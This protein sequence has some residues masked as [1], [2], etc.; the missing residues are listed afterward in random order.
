MLK[1]GNN[2]IRVLYVVENRSFGGGERGFGQ[3]STNLKKNRFQPFLAAHP[4]GQ[5]EE[6][7]QRAG[8]TFFP[9]DMS[10]KVN[11][12]TTGYLSRLISDHQIHIVHS[13]GA[14]ANFFARMACSRHSSTAVV[15]TVAMLVEGFDVSFLRKIVYQ[16]A[17]R[18]SARYVAH[19]ITVSKALKNKLVE[20]YG[21]SA[22]KVS[23][24][25]NG[26]EL[27]QYDPKLY[28]SEESRFSLGIKNDYPIIGT[29][30]RLVYQKGLP[31]F[32]EAAERVYSK[33]KKVRFVIIGQGP[34]EASLKHLADS[35][36]ITHLCTF[37]GQRFDINRLLSAID[38]FVLPSL[39]EG[40][41]RV[42]IE[43]MAMARPIVATDIHGVRE[44]ITHNHTGL[45]VEPAN[46][47][48]LAAAIMELLD[49]EQKA[50]RLAS[51]AQEY[52]KR[53]FDLTLT[54]NKTERLYENL[55]ESIS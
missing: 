48:L 18:Y 8:I 34:D 19:Y 51:N 36:G 28:S 46:P 13:M 37:A 7:A 23:V 1:F 43:A 24:I 15:C 54:V 50:N 14:R 6:I 52:A 44:Q 16:I 40:L 42:V 11:F 26:V 41:P 38:I 29:I 2:R 49:N 33:E 10:R 9:V 30:G 17:D 25:Y 39:L 32:L 22:D 47:K 4:G 27:D 21:I 5:L 31:Y 55:Y 20:K 53:N 12:K 3:L 45:L 35:L